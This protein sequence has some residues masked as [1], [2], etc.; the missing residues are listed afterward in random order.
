MTTPKKDRLQNASLCISPPNF[1]LSG[2]ETDLIT[3]E[4]V[5][6]E[7]TEEKVEA[8]MEENARLSVRQFVKSDWFLCKFIGIIL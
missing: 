8:L 4:T 6:L 7:M 2:E 5:P 1:N 3:T